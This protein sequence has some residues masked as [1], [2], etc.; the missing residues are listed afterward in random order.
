MRTARRLLLALSLAATL[1]SG[2][3]L[4]AQVDESPAARD[5]RMAWF[6][7]ARFG[8][9]IHWGVYAVPA[10]EW[11]GRTDHG[12]WIMET[13]KIPVSEYERFARQFNPVKFNARAWVRLAKAAGMKYIVITSKHHDGFCL[14]DSKLTDWDVMSTPFQRDILKE[15]AR[16]CRD[17]RIVLCFYHSIMDWHHPD[18]TKRRSWNDRAS[19]TPDMDRYVTYLKGQLAELLTGYGPLGILWF[20]GEW[21]EPWTHA[22]GVDLYQYVRSYQPAIIINNRVGKARAGM[23]GMD[24]GEERVGD[25]GTPEQEIPPTGFGPGVDWESCMTMNEHWGYNK[26]DQKWKSSTSLVRNLIDCA[27]KGG[28]YLLNVGPTAEGV[29]PR[30]SVE[31]LLEIGEW[32]VVNGE[33]IYGTSASPFAK[34]PW[35]RCTRKGDRLYLHVYDWPADGRLTVPVRSHVERAYLLASPAT[36]LKISKTPEGKSIHLPAAAPSPHASVVVLETRAPLEIGGE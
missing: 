31:R 9:F 6:R 11:Q 33:A 26:N 2:I 21:E 14:W 22:R 8:L 32:M 3:L 30:P 20:D 5:Q 29:I 23:A 15:L 36:P 1:F 27:S 34:L 28:N 10:G 4:R 17:E 12:E 25:Y 18:Y 19:G 35:G 13:G 16:V 7:E 24:K